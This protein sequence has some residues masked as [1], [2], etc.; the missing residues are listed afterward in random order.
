M[1]AL[2]NQVRHAPQVCLRESAGRAG[3]TATAADAVLVP[4]VPTRFVDLAARGLSDAYGVA[5]ASSSLLPFA[6]SSGQ[7]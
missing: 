7:A 2:V 1:L 6:G 5:F 4:E 3:L